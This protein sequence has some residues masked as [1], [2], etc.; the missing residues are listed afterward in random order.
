MR[1]QMAVAGVALVLSTSSASAHSLQA[2]KHCEDFQK[3]RAEL[4]RAVST[5]FVIVDQIEREIAKQGGQAGPA[6]LA[7][8]T[9]ARLELSR[10]QTA[11]TA[12]LDSTEA[13][14]CPD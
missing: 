13:K 14:D 6:Q 3:Q 4:G 2:T 8:R 7:A 5:A 12:L 9:T 1:L 10:A 11:E